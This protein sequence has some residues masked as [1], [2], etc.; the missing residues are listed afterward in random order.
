M[1]PRWKNEPCLT[2]CASSFHS[3][4]VIL[5]LVRIITRM[6]SLLVDA[7]SGTLDAAQSDEMADLS[8]KLPPLVRLLPPLLEN[9]SLQGDVV[10]SEM[11]SRLLKLGGSLR[12]SKWVSDCDL[13]KPVSLTAD[14]YSLLQAGRPAR[15]PSRQ[16]PARVGRACPCA[17]CRPRLVCA[18]TRGLCLG[19]LLYL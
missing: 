8:A 10:C 1:L 16:S 11:L 6:P 19:M 3:S 12:V 15:N 17:G 2:V 7:V 9:G 14:G 13:G 5:D 4:Q 18:V